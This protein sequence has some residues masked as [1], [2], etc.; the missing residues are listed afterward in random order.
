LGGNF[1]A[2]AVILGNIICYNYYFEIKMFSIIKKIFGGK[3]PKSR[4]IIP[5]SDH[6][7]DRKSLNKNAIR[8]IES[9]TENGFEAYLVGGAVR[10]LL[11]GIAP[12]DYDIV[13]NAKPAEVK[14]IFRNSLIIGRRFKL[15]HVRFGR[16]IIE[17]ATFRGEDKAFFGKKKRAINHT[18]MLI[19]DNIYGDLE[20]DVW[21]RDFSVNAL[22]Y[23]IGRREIIDY[24]N[25]YQDILAKKMRVIGEPEARYREDP[26]RMIRALRYATKLD[27]CLDASN[28]ACIGNMKDLLSTSSSERLLVE[29]IKTFHGGCSVKSFLAF[30]KHGFFA[31]L[32]PQIEESIVDKSAA[33]KYA[34]PL[35]MA[36]MHH[37]DARVKAGNT[38]NNA[39]LFIVMLWPQL[40]NNIL[41]KTTDK[42]VRDVIRETLK[43]YNGLLA[44]PKNMLETCEEIWQMQYIMLT[45]DKKDVLSM[46]KNNKFKMAYD[47]MMLR[48]Q[49][50][51][52]IS[53]LAIWWHRFVASDDENKSKMLDNYNRNNFKKPGSKKPFRPQSNRPKKT[54]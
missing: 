5:C 42:T 11:A 19:R 39:Y 10:D 49:V 36:A 14:K 34:L 47:F 8:V 48:A 44:L 53:G 32:L 20:S 40:Q 52:K 35:I 13:T 38:L 12:K 21:R 41:K 27:F 54:V 30:R 1:I 25:G 15:V 24:V 45:R 9:L 31:L 37:T 26:V 29:F 16:N 43:S 46:L 23:D 7:I 22:Y 6:S 28:V 50:E 33:Y 3:I 18:G 17:V 51:L 4:K 2:S